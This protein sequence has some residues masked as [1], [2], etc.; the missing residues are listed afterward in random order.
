MVKIKTPQKGRDHYESSFISIL[1]AVTPSYLPPP[2][3]TLLATPL[4]AAHISLF[5]SFFYPIL[6]SCQ[7]LDSPSDAN[8]KKHHEIALTRRHLSPTNVR[9]RHNGPTMLQ[10][11]LS[12]PLTPCFSFLS[13]NSC[14]V[15]LCA[16]FYVVGE[17]D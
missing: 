15:F 8:P 16:F 1:I 5:P 2:L 3:L 12:L 6:N 13:R 11:S 17:L 14:F 9:R 4:P 7:H 10:A